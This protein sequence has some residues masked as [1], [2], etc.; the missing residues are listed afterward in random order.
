MW[1]LPGMF[2]RARGALSY[3]P[4]RNADDVFYVGSGVESWLATAVG[5]I[6]VTAMIVL[7]ILGLRC[8]LHGSLR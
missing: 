8:L 5:S 7:G 6:L 2:I 1:P 3:G 4:H